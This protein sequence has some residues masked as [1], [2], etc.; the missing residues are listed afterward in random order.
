MVLKARFVVNGRF[1]EGSPDQTI[2]LNQILQNK[3][4]SRRVL[5]RHKKVQ[6]NLP[7]WKHNV[8]I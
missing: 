7:N 2:Y 4:E 1:L 6:D 5:E 8:P 3:F